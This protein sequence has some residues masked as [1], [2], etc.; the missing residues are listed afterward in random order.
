MV[1]RRFTRRRNVDLVAVARAL[2]EIDRP[3]VGAEA[4]AARERDG[5]I[6]AVAGA[7]MVETR[8]LDGAG[9]VNDQIVGA[10][11]APS[12]PAAR[13]AAGSV[14]GSSGD[15]VAAAC[16]TTGRRAGCQKRR[17]ASATAPA[18][19]AYLRAMPFYHALGRKP[20]G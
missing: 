10:R 8:M 20:K 15:D 7:K 14:T 6:V 3:G 9:D 12:V 5:S 17:A 16:S 18:T 2:R 1:A 13:C 11:V 19:N 4:E